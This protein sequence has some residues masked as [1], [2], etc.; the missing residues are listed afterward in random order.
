MSLFCATR[1]VPTMSYRRKQLQ[2]C[3]NYASI[4]KKQQ[5]SWLWQRWLMGRAAELA[6]GA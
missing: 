4:L 2:K 3:L 5:N 6:V 1:F